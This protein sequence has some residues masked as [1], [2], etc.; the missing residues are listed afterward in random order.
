MFLNGN[1][2]KIHGFK[3]FLSLILLKS[4]L[5]GNALNTTILKQIW[6]KAGKNS[7]EEAEKKKLE[8]RDGYR[9]GEGE[10]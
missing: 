4:S 8:E 5:I 7:L 1:D 2:L 3:Q 10:E 9:E 6:N